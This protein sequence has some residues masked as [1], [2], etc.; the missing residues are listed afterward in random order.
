MKKIA[1]II[2]ALALLAGIISF[3]PPA[4]AEDPVQPE[5]TIL[6]TVIAEVAEVWEEPSADSALLAEC[7]L[8]DT[9]YIFYQL[10]EY[11]FVQL[12]GIEEIQ[13]Y[14]L[15]EYVETDPEEPIPTAPPATPEPTEE[16]TPEP[17]EE[18]T[19]EPT[20]EP[21]PEPTEEPT[22]EPTEEPTPEPTEEPTAEPTEEPTP[23]PTDTPNPF[24]N[25]S[26][27]GGQSFDDQPDDTF[28]GTGASLS[29]D[30]P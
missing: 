9:V 26:N 7:V 27:T 18:P 12:P 24:V 6:G 20:E 10:E 5:D 2:I 11:Y 4:R 21:T 1:C 13:G 3:P 17:T 16:P 19:P 14:M 28:L 15:A 8:G 30:C 25:L 29:N 22:P 23:E